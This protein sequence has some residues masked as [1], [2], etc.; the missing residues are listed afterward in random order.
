MADATRTPMRS[1]SVPAHAATVD[2]LE[3]LATYPHVVVSWVDD[4]GYPVSVAT[5]FSVDAEGGTAVRTD[6][7]AGERVPGVP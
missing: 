3:R 7:A 1:G 6:N 5:S 2:D 4:A